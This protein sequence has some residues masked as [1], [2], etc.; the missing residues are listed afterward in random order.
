MTTSVFLG[1]YPVFPVFENEIELI[2]KCLSKKNKVILLS[3][4]GNNNYCT[5]NDF[6]KSRNKI[7]T[8]CK[9]CISRFEDGLSWLTNKDNLSVENLYNYKK[10]K[11]E[12]LKSKIDTYKTFNKKI[13]DKINDI[14]PILFEIA[15]TSLINITRDSNVDIKS[16]FSLFKKILNE[17]IDSYDS[18]INFYKSNSP[19]E[20]YIF[21]GMNYRYQPFLRETQKRISKSKIFIFEFPYI[22]FKDTVINKG[23]YS[24]DIINW[25]NELKKFFIKKKPS[26]NEIKKT[27]KWIN[28]RLVNIKDEYV[29]WKNNTKF[30][31]LNIKNHKKKIGFFF[32]SEFEVFQAKE[33]RKKFL[34]KNQIHIVK[35]LLELLKDKKDFH[36]YLKL[37]PNQ[38][39]EKSNLISKLNKLKKKHNFTLYSPDTNL[40]N[41]ALLDKLDL[42]VTTAS[43]IAAEASFR[44]KD[45]INI[46]PNL[47]NSF[48]TNKV[49]YKM[50]ELRLAII[51]FIN[52]GRVN[53]NLNLNSLNSLKFFYS[54]RNFQTKSIYLKRFNYLIGYL[55]RNKK[56]KYLIG[57]LYYF[58]LYIFIRIFYKLRRL[59]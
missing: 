12:D 41:F 8:V 31:E 9:F 37:H 33:Y 59:L 26:S 42:V 21:N 55:E 54:F 49:I 47:S 35:I 22:G 3:C 34:F 1:S 24:H 56:K 16:N 25:S 51:K 10:N 20:V 48:K 36:L 50:S 52:E 58:I 14:N 40:N 7:N 30:E 23:N 4:D 29:P 2:Q 15:L 53:K 18:S 13:I 32:S 27:K 57:S 43:S 45:V 44:K 28:N 46:G 17:T 19:D 38:R 6:L 39:F 5:A 11:F